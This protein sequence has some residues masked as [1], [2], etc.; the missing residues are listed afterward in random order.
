MHHLVRTRLNVGLNPVRCMDPQTKSSQGN[1][2]LLVA[3]GVLIALGAFLTILGIGAFMGSGAVE[4]VPEGTEQIASWMAEEPPL[5]ALSGYLS[6]AGNTALVIGALM[7]AH[8]AGWAPGRR[9]DVH[10]IDL[11]GVWAALVFAVI[12]ILPYDLAL[13]R[14]LIPLANADPSSPVFAAMFE[15]LDLTHSVGLV[16]FY[17]TTTALFFHQAKTAASD[18]AKWG[19]RVATAVSVMA[20]VV[21]LGLIVGNPPVFLIPSIF[22]TWFGVFWL[23]VRMVR[24]R[25]SHPDVMAGSTA[26][27]KDRRPGQG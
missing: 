4:N 15:T 10:R 16:V 8:L 26:V 5:L 17:I 7:L 13:P 14:G 19:W 2:N 1:T 23:G 20:I 18:S 11:P 12:L 27:S 9:D 24:G 21:A 6:I 25:V 22:L 3:P